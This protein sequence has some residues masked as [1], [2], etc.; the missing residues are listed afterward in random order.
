LTKLFFIP[1]P[2]DY[3]GDEALKAANGGA[4]RADGGKIP[5]ESL[6]FVNRSGLSRKVDII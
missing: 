6:G 1:A 3:G 2:V 5:A 4:K